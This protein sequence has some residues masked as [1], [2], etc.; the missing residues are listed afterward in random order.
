MQTVGLSLHHLVMI[1]LQGE[2]NQEP[3][4]WLALGFVGHSQEVRF[5]EQ[6]EES[7]VILAE[8]ISNVGKRA[9]VASL[10]WNCWLSPLSQVKDVVFWLQIML[11]VQQQRMGLMEGCL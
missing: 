2:S 6:S 3:T 8:E 9:I 7:H 4:S 10:S 1:V 11:V 5:Y